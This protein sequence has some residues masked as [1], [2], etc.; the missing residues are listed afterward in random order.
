VLARDG[1]QWRLLGTYA[2]DERVRAPPFEAL[3]L[4]VL[5]APRPSEQQGW[6]SI[7]PSLRVA[8][9]ASP[10]AQTIDRRLAGA[11]GNAPGEESSRSAISTVP[12]G[13]RE[14]GRSEIV[15]PRNELQEQ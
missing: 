1:P 9:R 13:G 5:W 6:L 7:E 2:D 14:G 8:A 4:A 11:H 15:P 10:G 3:E 12:G